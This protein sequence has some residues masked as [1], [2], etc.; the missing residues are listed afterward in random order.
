[1]FPFITNSGATQLWQYEKST[2]SNSHFFFISPIFLTLSHKRVVRGSMRD[3]CLGYVDSSNRRRKSQK[4]SAAFSKFYLSNTTCN[5]TN[6]I[7][8]SINS[9]LFS[10]IVIN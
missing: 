6:V 5:A 7:S 9:E 10:A 3:Y 2:V 1:M 4:I 8:L